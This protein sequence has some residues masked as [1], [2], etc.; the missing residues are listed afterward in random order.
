MGGT[1]NVAEACLESGLRRLVFASTIEI[2][3]PQEIAGPLDEDAPKRFTGT[4]SRTKWECEQLLAAYQQ[5]QGLETVSLRLPMVLGPG[6]YHEAA[7]LRMFHMIRRGL[8][9]PVP[10]RDIPYSA[11]GAADCADAFVLAAKR[12]AASGQVCNIAAPDTPSVAT[13]VRDVAALV[14]S[15]SRPLRVATP[16]VRAAMAAAKGMSR[17]TRGRLPTTPAELMDFALV[18]GAYSID[19]ARRVLGYAPAMTCAEAWATTYIWY[20][21][22]RTR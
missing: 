8:P 13:F 1:R 19:R 21:G 12:P 17:L 9:I 3:G 15:R 22:E 10:A 14:D 5:S 11:V 4:Y 18:G 2:Y 6:F 7:V 16:L 20:F